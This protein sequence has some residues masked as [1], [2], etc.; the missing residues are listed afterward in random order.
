VQPKIL[1]PAIL[2]LAGCAP[3]LGPMPV[4]KAPSDLA[5]AA[6]LAG[7]VSAWPEE[8]W[9]RSYADLQLDTLI[10]EARSGSPQ[11]AAALARVRAADALAEQSRAALTPT[12]QADGTATLDK[13]SYNTA[14]PAQF[15]PRGWNDSGRISL[16]G[17]FDL[18]LWG[19]NRAAL[20]AARGEAAAAA[21]DARQAVMLLSVGVADAYADLARLYADRDADVT[22]VTIRQSSVDLAKQRFASGLD[23]RG[24]EQ[25]AESRLAAAQADLSAR[26]EAIKLTRN[27]IAALLGAGPDRGLTIA[28][29]RV[30]ALRPSGLPD[31]LSLNLIGRRPDLVSAR[32]RAEAASSRIR[33]AKAAYYPNIS[34]SALIGL[35]S[36]GLNRLIDS[37]STYGSVGPAFSLPIFDRPRLNGQLRGARAAYDQAVANYDDS[38]ITALKEV[39]DAADSMRALAGRRAQA[40]AALTAAQNA[41][42]IAKQR[43]EGGLSTYLD[44][45]TAEDAVLDRRRVAADLEAR[46][47]TLDVALVRALGGGFTDTTGTVPAVKAV[48]SKDAH[49]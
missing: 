16:S 10:A 17:G 39:T 32:L 34:L 30:A 12:V 18:D 46:G 28:R 22:A 3:A 11:V 42:G 41:Y 45:L 43:F 37:G 31:Q 35:Q 19:R 6:S 15:V 33:A 23:N 21:V 5:S 20:A 49:G 2:L 47:F 4:A 8:E 26:D 7:P 9:W 29:P 13:N 40:T 14:I 25:L 27:R 48:D 1:L 36:L 24:V 44:V 38:L